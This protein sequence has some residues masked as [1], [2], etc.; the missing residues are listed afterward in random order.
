MAADTPARGAHQM[1]SA[2]KSPATLRSASPSICTGELTADADDWSPAE[3]KC[4]SE[5]LPPSVL[6]LTAVP[7]R[8]GGAQTTASGYTLGSCMPP[9]TLPSSS[10]HGRRGFLA[11]AESAPCARD[12]NTSLCDPQAPL[13]AEREEGDPQLGSFFVLIIRLLSGSPQP[14]RRRLH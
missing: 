8:L 6:D 1:S 12:P 5:P 10:A 2:V 14:S 11:S 7:V 13:G 4:N 9:L 3:V